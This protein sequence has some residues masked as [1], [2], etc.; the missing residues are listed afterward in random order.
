MAAVLSIFVSGS[1]AGKSINVCALLTLFFAPLHT[2]VHCHSLL[3]PARPVLEVLQSLVGVFGGIAWL[4]GWCWCVWGLGVECVRF[5]ERPWFL[6]ESFGG[7]SNQLVLLMRPHTLGVR[8]VLRCVFCALSLACVMA[9]L[10][11]RFSAAGKNADVTLAGGTGRLKASAWLLVSGGS[12]ACW[13]VG[14]PC[15]SAVPCL[16]AD[17]ICTLQST[18]PTLALVTLLSRQQ[19]L[20]P[21]CLPACFRA[22]RS[23]TARAWQCRDRQAWLFGRH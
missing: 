6:V 1:L 8:V 5:A 23:A 13:Q 4:T 2:L 18:T 10:P 11:H 9:R 17:G 21:A 19:V 20:L 3:W 15:C 14:R 16:H 12:V 22:P 7:V